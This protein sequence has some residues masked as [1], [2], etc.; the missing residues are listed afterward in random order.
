[1][2]RRDAYTALKAKVLDKIIQGKKQLV[3]WG[4]TPQGQEMVFWTS[5]P[6]LAILVL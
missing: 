6:H 5:C 4:V 3:I 1:M 2:E